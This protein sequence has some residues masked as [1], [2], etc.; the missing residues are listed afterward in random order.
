MTI[1]IDFGTTNTTIA[2]FNPVTCAVEPIAVDGVVKIPSVIYWPQ[3]E[4]L[5]RYGKA[6][7]RV[8]EDA[9]KRIS[10]AEKSGDVAEVEKGEEILWG[11]VRSIKEHLDEDRIVHDEQQI[12]PEE[13]IVPFF[14]YL[15]D[16]VLLTASSVLKK[17][18]RLAKEPIEI[19]LTHPVEWWP[20]SIRYETLKSAAT[21]AGFSVT[22][23]LS[24]PVAAIYG[25]ARQREGMHIGNGVLVFD[26]GGGT[27]DVAYLTKRCDGR[28]A[29]SVQPRGL[30]LAGDKFDSRILEYLER[31]Y[32]AKTGRSFTDSERKLYQR[33]ARDIKHRLS[34]EKSV[35]FEP[36]VKMKDV[37]LGKDVWKEIV[38]TEINRKNLEEILKDDLDNIKRFLDDFVG[39]VTKAKL[40]IDTVLLVG[41][42]TQMPII[43][44]L[45][46]SVTHIRPIRHPQ[47]DVLVALGAVKLSEKESVANRFFSDVRYR[48]MD[49]DKFVNG[50]NCGPLT[51]TSMSA[52][53]QKLR[54]ALSVPN[55]SV[56]YA[57]WDDTRYF[58]EDACGFAISREGI[59]IKGRDEDRSLFY[60]WQ[61]VRTV[62]IN[63]KTIWVEWFDKDGMEF[64]K[65]RYEL[66]RLDLNASCSIENALEISNRFLDIGI[67]VSYGKEK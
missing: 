23:M 4:H 50:G 24:E 14:E 12:R 26:L 21:K 7:E 59:W 35:S 28:Y 27:L 15:K 53:P 36:L 29:P 67:N 51:M 6:A 48:R 32:E 22:E 65:S 9:V 5:R 43:Q 40:S 46:E 3:K 33:D 64:Y 31:E 55:D 44:K 62:V 25:A 42:S 30:D 63:Y 41:G 37:V 1:S 57:Y 60:N 16:Y 39:I 58:W 20:R 49:F 19:T 10:N 66:K 13:L 38:I 17:D 52:L 8:F 2:W 61:N 56:I 34:N 45:V 18:L 54:D 11:I 47:S